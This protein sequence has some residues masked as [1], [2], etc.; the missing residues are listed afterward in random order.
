MPLL[1]S[2]GQNLLDEGGRGWDVQ[3]PSVLHHVV[4]DR[5]R[6]PAGACAHVVLDG[7]EGQI[8]ELGLA[9]TRNEIEKGGR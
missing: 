8:S 5:P 6:R 4:D 9:E 7:D 2:G 1:M 3:A